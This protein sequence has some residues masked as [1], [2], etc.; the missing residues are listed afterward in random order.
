MAWH[1]FGKANN[2]LMKNV[3][4]LEAT[5]DDSE[6]NLTRYNICEAYILTVTH[7]HTRFA[8]ILTNFSSVQRRLTITKL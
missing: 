6:V 2:E 5:V 4:F 7:S 3:P 8:V 1:H